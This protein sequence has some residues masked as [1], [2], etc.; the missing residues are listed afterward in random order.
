MV[1]WEEGETMTAAGES[2]SALL[3]ERA[4]QNPG[5]LF[6][7][8]VDGDSATYGTVYERSLGWAHAFSALG[9]TSGHHVL[10]MLPN[11]IESVCAWFGLNLLNAVEVPVHLDY[12]GSML[13]HLVRTSHPTVVVCNS[14]YVER[15]TDFPEELGGVLAFVVADADTAPDVAEK[16]PCRVVTRDE[17]FRA[18]GRATADDSVV[19]EAARHDLSTILFTSGTTGLSKAVQI[20][21][22]QL[23][24][25]AQGAFPIELYDEADVYYSPLPLYH[26]AA[27]AILAGMLIANAAVVICDRFTITSFWE[28]V[29][30]Y[31]CTATCLMGAMVHFLM[32]QPVQDS[33]RQHPMR[34][35][36]MIPLVNNVEEAKQRFNWQVATIYNQTEISV[37]IVS[38]GWNISDPSSCGRLRPGFEARIVDDF[39]NEV[40]D[41][42]IGELVIRADDP[43]TLMAGYYQMPEKT[44]ETWRNLWLHTGDGFRRD[45]AGNYYFVDRFKDVIRR[46]GENISSFEVEQAVREHP[47]VLECAAVAVPSEFNE[48][49]VKIVVVLKDGQRLEP[50]AL[51]EFL[52]PQMPRFMLPRYIE[53]AAELPKTPTQKIRKTA[54]REDP[55]NAATW[56]SKAGPGSRSANVSSP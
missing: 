12:Q 18:G 2:L 45:E 34:K 26:T 22:A 35:I 55:F 8:E 27:K 20:P 11:S 54:L 7:Q 39:D 23:I 14:D 46:R 1:V 10:V 51:Y 42:E 17:F 36:L 30:R 47:A 15:F 50:D 40:P 5:K 32:G 25:A 43:W 31:E 33:D 48:D 24:A 13:A 38:D 28:H 29:D 9:V 3:R 52:V 6:L 21:H 53:F 19:V 16:L 37:P 4:E 49:E 44:V 56:D 41:G